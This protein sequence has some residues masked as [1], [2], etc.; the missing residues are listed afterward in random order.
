MRYIALLLN[1]VLVFFVAKM[2]FDYFSGKE[3]FFL[4]NA[5]PAGVVFIYAI[6]YFMVLDEGRD[7][8]SMY[9]HL[10][11]VFVVIAM[12][13]HGATIN[14]FLEGAPAWKVISATITVATLFSTYFVT[15]KIAELDG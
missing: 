6:G 3:G 11:G 2:S 5:A 4:L 8:S 13:I 1:T 9:Q 12:L 10:I 14:V 7:I 15:K